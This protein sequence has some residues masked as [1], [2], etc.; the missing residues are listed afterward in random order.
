M[1]IES[2]Q[3]P[4]LR[5]TARRRRLKSTLLGLLLT[6]GAV[7]LIPGVATADTVTAAES[8]QAG[9]TASY[10]LALANESPVAHDYRLQATGMPGDAAAT[11]VQDGPVLDT[12]TLE[13]G[14]STVFTLRVEVPS[15]A[16]LGR[17]EGAIAVT[18]DDGTTLTFPLVLYVENIFSLKIVGQSSNV[19]TFS[20]KEFTFDI[21]VANT[22]AAPLTNLAAKVD[23]PSSWE[24][25][26]S[27]ETTAELAPGAET[28]FHISVL[29]PASQVALDQHVPLQVTSDQAAS[30]AESLAV[31]VQTNPN[32]LPIAG[33]VLAAALL[34]VGLYFRAKGRR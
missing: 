20:G 32:Y 27:P 23:P 3:V 5:R 34:G 19:T 24:V 9:A 22:G 13:P 25:R 1:H 7:A 10:Q 33:G 21:T 17:H 30:E 28:V 29:V 11:F 4:R 26:P 8:V 12:V 6:V 15:D 31:R 16:A 18:R 2:P 14:T